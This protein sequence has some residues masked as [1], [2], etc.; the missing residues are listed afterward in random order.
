MVARFRTAQ[1][2]KLDDSTSVGA[3]R[4][5]NSTG[6]VDDRL[7]W[8]KSQ[9]IFHLKKPHNRREGAAQVEMATPETEA[10]NRR[11]NK[12]IGGFSWGSVASPPL[13]RNTAGALLFTSLWCVA[14]CE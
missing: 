11:Q 7:V 14:L 6:W 12:R 8:T 2:E 13:A 5:Q 4:G 10:L 1:T 3:G 9:V